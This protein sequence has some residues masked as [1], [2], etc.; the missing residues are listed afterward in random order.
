MFSMFKYSNPIS[1]LATLYKHLKD[2]EKCWQI[3]YLFQ[4]QIY[5]ILNSPFLENLYLMSQWDQN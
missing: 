3:F 5:K 2:I 4:E 1:R